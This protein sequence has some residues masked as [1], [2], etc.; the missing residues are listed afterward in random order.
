MLH[1][2]VL[3]WNPTLTQ[4]G[5]PVDGYNIYR[6]DST[7]TEAGPP[8]N[9]GTLIPGTSFTDTVVVTGRVYYY[10]VKAVAAGLESTA[11][12]EVITVAVPFD[13]TV[14]PLNV[15][16]ASSFAVL[17]ATAIT[18]TGPTIVDGDIGIAPGTSITGMTS[19]NYTGVTHID[20][21]V[22]KAAQASLTAA[23]NAAKVATNPGGVAPTD[24]G[25][26]VDLGGKTL[27]PGVYSAPDSVGITGTLILDAEGNQDA[28][29]I[30]QVGTALTV[31]GQIILKNGAQASNVFWQIGS[32]ATIGTG[33]FMVGIL[34]AKIS[35]TLVTG[36][37]VNGQ[38]LAMTGAVTMDT[39]SVSMF[40]AT[41]LALN[42]RNKFFKVGT[43]IFDCAT[44][45]FQEV[46]AAGITFTSPVPFNSTVGATTQDGSVTWLTLDPPVGAFVGLPPSG[47]NVPPVAPPAPTGLKIVSEQ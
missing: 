36:A 46:I 18:N 47:P 44:Q 5:Q 3:S 19:A 7:G 22:S 31:A 15:G 40:I 13:P 24:L 20:D 42:A 25:T 2:V 27:V 38:V 37:S 33:S 41:T 8:L 12:N 4:A 16:I 45:T 32:S 6:S 43:I 17:A 39:N 9:D 10:V 21:N 26:A 35:I 28:V 23:F 34:M 14:P 30:F 11:S 29:W 1:D